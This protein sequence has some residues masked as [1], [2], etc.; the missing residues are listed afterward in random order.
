MLAEREAVIMKTQKVNF[1]FRLSEELLKKLRYIAKQ[2]CRSTSSMIRVLI[3]DYVAAF[4]RKH[5]KI[6]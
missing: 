5:G 1:G 4:E 3:Y 2:D 6:S